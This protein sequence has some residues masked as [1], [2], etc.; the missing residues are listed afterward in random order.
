ML[1]PGWLSAKI[2][3]KHL[4]GGG[5]LCT[6]ILTLLT[7]LCAN[8]NVYLLIFIRILEGLFEVCFGFLHESLSSEAPTAACLIPVYCFCLF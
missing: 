2:G 7:P 5:I 1:L 8:I 4:F 3:G 6:A